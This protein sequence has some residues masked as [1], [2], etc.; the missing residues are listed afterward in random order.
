MTKNKKTTRSVVTKQLKNIF[1]SN[2]LQKDSVCAIFAH[3]AEEFS[4]VQN[5]GNE[6]E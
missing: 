4:V 3:T 1:S 6:H 5:D 2:E